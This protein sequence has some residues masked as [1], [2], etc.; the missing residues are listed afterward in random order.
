MSIEVSLYLKFDLSV[1]NTDEVDDARQLAARTD[2]ELYCWK[3][4]GVSNWLDKGL[5]IADVLGI[6]VLPRGLPE[7]IDMLDDEEIDDEETDD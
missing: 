6:V 7:Q 2:G 3:T 4:A 1:F 5:S